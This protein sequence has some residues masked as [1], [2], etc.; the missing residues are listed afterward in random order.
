MSTDEA[1]AVMVRRAAAAV[2]R[3]SIDVSRLHPAEHCPPRQAGDSASNCDFQASEDAARWSAG[4]AITQ[5]KSMEAAAAGR[6]AKL[7]PEASCL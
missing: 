4:A 1:R 6:F 7:T 2:D 3:P 5:P